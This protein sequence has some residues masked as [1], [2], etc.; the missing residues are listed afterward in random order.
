MRTDPDVLSA[1]EQEAVRRPDATAAGIARMIALDARFTGRVPGERTVRNL[2]RPIREAAATEAA[3]QP[4]DFM[5]PAMT[6]EDARLVM[7]YIGE[8]DR[9]LR[10]SARLAGRFVRIRRAYPEMPPLFAW[11][12]AV[13]WG[14][15]AGRERAFT[16]IAQ[17]GAG[18]REEQTND[19]T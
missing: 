14:T 17:V 5:D 15:A 12:H 8:Q 10:P 13:W 16:Y 6:P 7:D 4:W 1:I 9:P 2:I 18:L 11:T 3:G 19:P